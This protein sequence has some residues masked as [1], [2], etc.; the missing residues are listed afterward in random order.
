MNFTTDNI[1]GEKHLYIGGLKDPEYLSNANSVISSIAGCFSGNTINSSNTSAAYY[2]IDNVQ[3]V[4]LN[5]I[6]FNLP[7]EICSNESVITDLSDFVSNVDPTGVFSGTG[8]SNNL[9]VYSFNPNIAGEGIHTITYTFI[10][11]NGCEIEIYDSIEVLS[12]FDPL[13]SCQ[14]SLIFSTLETNTPIVFN[15][16]DF[17]ET[18]TNYQVNSG[19]DVTLKAGNNISIK[20]DSQISQGSIFLARIE[21][22]DGTQTNKINSK[23]KEVVSLTDNFYRYIDNS[24]YEEYIENEGLI[25]YPNPLT[26]NVLN[27]ISK[28]NDA[29]T[30]QIFNVLG[31]L[32]VNSP[33]VN[34]QISIS[35]L[36]SGIYIVKITENDKVA[37][38]KLIIK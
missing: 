8:V 24:K 22:C 38:R 15:T 6:V 14:P 10:N 23:S 28:N 12:E 9:G 17:I 5:D 32:V 26:G 18:N 19:Y 13:C 3:L 36:T 34:K 2:Y 25:L 16:S 37:T 30:V 33:V 1:A 27:I 31:E 11:S 35:N 7:E 29:M 20:P 4:P 21:N